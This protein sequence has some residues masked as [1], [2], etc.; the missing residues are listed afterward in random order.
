MAAQVNGD[1]AV[2][3]SV[4]ERVSRLEEF[5]RE[6]RERLA[7]MEGQ[8]QLLLDRVG[9]LAARMDAFEQRMDAFERRLDSYV[10]KDALEAATA[11]LQESMAKMELR[12]MRWFVVTMLASASLV[13]TAA[14]LLR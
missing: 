4:I 1:D 2:G 10:T 13:F 11:K 3:L 5:A 8:L 7:R 12:L 14:Q 6:T 9:V